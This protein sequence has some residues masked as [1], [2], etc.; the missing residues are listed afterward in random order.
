MINSVELDNDLFSGKP[1]RKD[2]MFPVPTNCARV[3]IGRA[4][5][6]D[7]HVVRN[8]RSGPVGV[9]ECRGLRTGDISSLNFPAFIY[10][11]FD[12]AFKIFP[13]Q[14]FGGGC[15]GIASNKS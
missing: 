4:Y 14:A 6:G 7:A 8:T 10:P 12:T 15:M 5:L 11:Q 9:I 13:L 3:I 1:W 2:E